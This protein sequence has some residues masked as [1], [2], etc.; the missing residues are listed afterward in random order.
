MYPVGDAE[1]LLHVGPML[2]NRSI[3]VIFD[4]ERWIEPHVEL[5]LTVHEQHSEVNV[6]LIRSRVY[7]VGGVG[8]ARRV[9][10]RFLLIGVRGDLNSLNVYT[11]QC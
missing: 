8:R 7:I 10:Q 3:H 2:R 5:R 11:C 4:P 6:P 1:D 9:D